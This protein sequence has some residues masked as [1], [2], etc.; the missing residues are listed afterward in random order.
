M[1]SSISVEELFE[2]VL[3]SLRATKT[4]ISAIEESQHTMDKKISELEASNLQNVA[5]IRELRELIL[6]IKLLQEG[7]SAYPQKGFHTRSV[8]VKK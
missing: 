7:R 1:G 4:T 3:N 8:R 2:S 6:D 5:K